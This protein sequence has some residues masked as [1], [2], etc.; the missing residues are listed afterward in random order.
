MQF[1]SDKAEYSSWNAAQLKDWLNERD[2]HVPNGYDTDQM[3]KLVEANW[4]EGVEWSQEQYN[5][6]QKAFQDVRQSSFDAW[7]ESRL[8]QFLL[9]QVCSLRLVHNDAYADV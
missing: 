5:S 7:D 1:G 6:A 2:I 4:N 3:R 8:R 9:E